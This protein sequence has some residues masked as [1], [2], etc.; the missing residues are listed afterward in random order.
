MARQNATDDE[1]AD[2]T[3]FESFTDRPL[4]PEI[5]DNLQ[6][7][8]GTDDHPETLSA[9]AD[10]LAAAF[11]EDWPPAVADLCHDE[12][13]RHRAETEGETY[14][15][16]CVL[17]AVMLPFLTDNSA[18]TVHSGG[19][20]TGQTVVSHVSQSGIETDPEEAVLSFGVAPVAPETEPTPRL[21][22][23]SLCPYVHAF[24]EESAYERWAEETD[25]PTIGL[26]LSEGFGLARA[27]A[28]A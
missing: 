7:L 24:P 11:G 2:E 21:T 1:R 17:D 22:Y 19:P 23:E 26:P 13:G 8:F 15:F 18:V 12:E 10:M 3:E 16:V 5:A 28:R 4:P 9:W 6:S 25:A 20:E 27:L 14:R